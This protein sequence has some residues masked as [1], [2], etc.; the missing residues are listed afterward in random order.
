MKLVRNLAAALVLACA[1]TVN[2]YAGDQNTPGFVPPTPPATYA[3]L[4]R[5]RLWPPRI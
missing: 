2:V 1:L 3:D 4:V 5:M